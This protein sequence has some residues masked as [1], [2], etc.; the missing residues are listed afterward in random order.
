MKVAREKKRL[1]VVF[2]AV[3]LFV[4]ACEVGASH[5]DRIILIL[6]GPSAFPLTVPD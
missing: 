5:E 2:E 3:E 1:E 6:K 4:G